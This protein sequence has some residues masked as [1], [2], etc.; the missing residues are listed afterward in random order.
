MPGRRPHSQQ[1][2]T[3]LRPE[4]VRCAF[5][6]G[7]VAGQLG[8]SVIVGPP[9]LKQFVPELDRRDG[10][11]PSTLYHRIA[12]QTTMLAHGTRPLP[13]GSEF[14]TAE[15]V[16]AYVHSPVNDSLSQLLV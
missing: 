13:I 14:V 15:E 10:A 2:T 3:R 12:L 1:V 9:F 7:R 5:L 16:G 6:T 4:H 11:T 8:N